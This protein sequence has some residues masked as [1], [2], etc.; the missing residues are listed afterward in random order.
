[1]TSTSFERH[2]HGDDVGYATQA[3][4][5][6]WQ[7]RSAPLSASA[8]DLRGRALDCVERVEHAPDEGKERITRLI[9]RD[10]GTI[11][12]QWAIATS[13]P[14]YLSAFFRIAHDPVRG[15][16]RWTDEEH[17]AFDRVEQVRESR[18][19]GLTDADGGFLVPFQLDPSVILTS[20]GSVN[21]YRQVSRVVT[22]TSDVWHGVS[23]AGITASYDQEFEEVS[24]DSPVLAQPTVTIRT[25]RAFVPVSLEAFQDAQNIAEEVGRLIA[26]AKD[27]LEAVAFTSGTAGANQPVGIVTALAGTSSELPPATAEAFAPGDVYKVQEALP[28]RFQNNAV[29]MA[30]RGTINQVRRFWNPT[31][32]EPPLLESG[33][34]LDRPLFE[35][36]QLPSSAA[37][38]PTV[39][40]ANAGILIYG[41]F[42][43]AIIAERIGLTVEFIP[44][45]FAG[46]ATGRPTGAR[47]WFGWF[48]H[49]YNVDTINAFRMLSVPTS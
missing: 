39:T 18:A 31:G 1:M 12:S 40:A 49:G 21:A 4:D 43:H 8:P 16:L 2:E 36:S 48:R 29:W 32:T 19:M 14:A 13:D 27:Q 34:L 6:P 24:D 30:A 44:H 38:N 22:A 37:I 41:D 9:E 28:P 5:D 33:R 42:S 7:A 20:A 15:H 25:A 46:S 3:T 45:L 10:T 26:D 47:G 35:N 17:R 11:A 23:S